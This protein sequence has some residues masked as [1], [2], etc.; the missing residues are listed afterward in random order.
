SILSSKSFS[1]MQTD[2]D[3][4]A[5]ALS[6]HC[7]QACEKLRDQ[8]LTTEHLSIFIQTNRHRHDLPSYNPTFALK[9]IH[10]TDDIR[11]ITSEAKRSL[12]KIF[13][14]GFHYKKVGILLDHLKQKNAGSYQYDLLDNITEASLA[15]TEQL[16]SVLDRINQ[17]FGRHTVKLAATGQGKP[18]ITTPSILCSPCYTT[19]WSD[20][21]VVKNL[22]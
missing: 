6:Q 22:T 9:L 12:K 3:V 10:P 16:L 17:K 5:Q 15:Q 4:L 1:N 7:A 20:L 8:S 13:K 18:W 21:P 14:P 2:F 11:V 19:R